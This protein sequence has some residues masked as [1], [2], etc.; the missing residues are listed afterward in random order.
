MERR[1]E[2]SIEAVK[3]Y[4]QQG[5]SQAEVATRMGL[6]RPTVAKLLAHGRERGFVTIEIHD[7][8]EDASEIALRL[9]QHFGLACARVAH[10]TGATEDEAIEQ[11]GRVG[12]DAHGQRVHPEPVAGLARISAPDVPSKVLRRG[13][14]N[15]RGQRVRARNGQGFGRDRAGVGVDVD[16][17][18]HGLAFFRKIPVYGTAA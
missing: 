6:S 13:A 10:G 11:V 17:R 8:R 7:P 16:R 3:L 5:L 12:A 1:D 15:D 9:E 4:Y 18:S 14:R 2:Q